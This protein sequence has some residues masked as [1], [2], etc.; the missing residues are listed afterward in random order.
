LAGWNEENINLYAA[1]KKL[2]LPSKNTQ[3]KSKDVKKK[4]RMK[5]EIKLALY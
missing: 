1:Y 5:I 3:T 2:T 4:Y